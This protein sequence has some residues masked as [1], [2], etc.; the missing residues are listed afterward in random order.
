MPRGRLSADSAPKVYL[1]AILG[2][3]VLSVAVSFVKG[4]AY[5]FLSYAL[6]Q[7]CYT[8]AIIGYLKFYKIRPALAI[9][10]RK[11]I[12]P[13]AVLLALV[14]TVGIY[15]QNLI[16][17]VSFQWLVQAVGL[18]ASVILPDFTIALNL[19]LGVLIVCIL[20]AIGEELLFRGV[21][22]SS[23]KEKGAVAAVLLS[24]ALFSLSHGN[25]V[26]LVHQFL[27]GVILAYLTL[28]TGNIIYAMIIHF[29]NNLLAITLPLAVPAYNTLAVCNLTNAIIMSGL[30]VV[31]VIVLYPSLKLL[32]KKAGGEGG[33][34]SFFIKKSSLPCYNSDKDGGIDVSAGKKSIEMVWLYALFIFLFIQ[35]VMNTVLTAIPAVKDLLS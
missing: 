16:F 2:G 32:V 5:I 27:L 35:L 7:L 12:K 6:P 34:F 4:D 9:P 29:T 11:P 24:A 1:A 10:F 13:V 22:L 31:G 25:I 20:P 14:V 23:L 3:F 30:F 28:K 18:E 17:A 15:A 26:Q 19:I 21:T 33:F 8:V